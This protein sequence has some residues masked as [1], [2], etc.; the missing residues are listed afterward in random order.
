[1]TKDAEARSW[2]TG[3]PAYFDGRGILR[4][5][6]ILEHAKYIS[7]WFKH[8]GLTRSQLQAFYRKVRRLGDSVDHV[9]EFDRVRREL[10]KLLPIA[11]E[12]AQKK[13]IPQV[14]HEFLQHNIDKSTDRKWL[15]EGF[16]E[17]FQAVVGYCAGK[18]KEREG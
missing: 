10:Q 4:E 7:D 2:P 15:R 14:F 3:Y 6:Y 9:P 13:V 18:L 8:E 12:R 1:M 11:N 5:E 16:I 17:H